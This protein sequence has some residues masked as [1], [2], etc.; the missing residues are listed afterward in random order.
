MEEIVSKKMPVSI[1]NGTKGEKGCFVS[2]GE[3][4]KRIVFSVIKYSVYFCFFLLLS[5]AVVLGTFA[6]FAIG[7]FLALIWCGQNIPLCS[8]LFLVASLIINPGL[9]TL[10]GGAFSVFFILSVCMW[11]TK[12][13]KQIS[14][15]LFSIYAVL[16]QAGYLFSEMY[17]FGNFVYSVLNVFLVVVCGFASIKFLEAILAGGVVQRLSSAEISGLF[18]LMLGV[19]CGLVSV[20]IFGF[21]VLK[22]FAVIMI[23]ET[24]LIFGGAGGLFCG[25]VLGLS[26]LLIDFDISYLT[27][28]IV[29][30]LVAGLFH[31]KNRLYGVLA[32]C[33]SEVLIGFFLNVYATYTIIAALPVILG[34]ICF[35]LVPKLVNEYFAGVFGVGEGNNA[36]KDV[37]NRSR[38]SLCR[39]FYNLSEIFAEIDYVFRSMVRGAM[40]KEQVKNYIGVEV[41]DRVCHSC[42]NKN[43]CHR[44]HELQTKDVFENMVESALERGKSSLLDVSPHLTAR[45]AKVGQI[46]SEINFLT[47]QHKNYA[48]VVGKLDAGR[49]LVAEQ[50]GGI[51]KI[52]K[53]LA[54]EV[55][56]NVSFD[57]KRE[58]EIMSELSFHN[59]VC[60]EVV[61]YEQNIDIVC[62][63]LLVKREV[64]AVS[65]IEKI[66]GQ[67][68]KH[69]MRAISEEPSKKAGWKMISL[70]TSPK[71]D[72]IFGTASC[73]KDGCKISGD[74]Y[75]IIRISQSQ[76]LLAVSDGMGSG[77][78][79]EKTSS[80]A[81]GLIENFYKAGFDNDIILSSINK[82]LSIS[83]E[84]IFSTLD[85]CVIDTYNGTADFIKMGAPNSYVKSNG[86]TEEIKGGALPLGIVQEI[87]PIIRKKVFK[88]GDIMFLFSDG[89]S[90]SFAT[91]EVL[92]DFINNM[93]GLNPQTLAENL[94]DKAIENSGGAKD[95][96]TVICAKIFSLE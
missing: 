95:D 75:S 29:F 55:R 64:Q 61:V 20:D 24:S 77:E 38:E 63:T 19:A 56:K 23:L 17:F 67:I 6:P 69:K 3:R 31:G 53:N 1:V 52:M 4:K 87:E 51:S 90:D 70:Q 22:L 25:S 49:V 92:E 9:T 39:R 88:S 8:L 37:V 44:M 21:S 28:F 26:P 81:L 86:Q 54:E 11:H 7:F 93:R 13:K 2:N 62:V 84:E 16:S 34:G 48:S 33:V 15:P 30:A 91:D 14:L 60:G 72:I 59:I 79:A 46:V 80:L 89:V 65:K 10:I 45:C 68:C 78:K 96:L 47:N 58:N 18:C 66:V 73:A 35:L 50:L 12:L 5:N 27:A 36:L 42:P 76:Y 83:K 41:K 40:T 43:S 85:I 57:T 74:C 71:Y 32:V 82:L 94:L